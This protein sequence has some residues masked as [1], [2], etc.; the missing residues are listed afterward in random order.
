MRTI[1]KTLPLLL[2]LAVIFIANVDAQTIKS[3]FDG[4]L[5]DHDAIIG[6]DLTLD[7]VTLTPFVVGEDAITTTT[8]IAH[9]LGTTP[10]AVLITPQWGAAT[11]TQ[12]VFVT[13]VT[14]SSFDAYLTTGSETGANIF[15]QAA[16]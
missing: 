3:R 5:V 8:T 12:T 14:A 15:W 2:L 9:T 11:I 13:N 4:I 7:G 16:E 10:T 6:G 1:L